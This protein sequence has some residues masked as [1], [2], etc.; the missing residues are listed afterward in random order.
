ML[1]RASSFRYNRQGAPSSGTVTGS[2]LIICRKKKWCETILIKSYHLPD[3]P[4]HTASDSS[5]LVHSSTLTI[6]RSGVSNS[7]PRDKSAWRL[8]LLSGVVPEFDLTS[9]QWSRNIPFCQIW[10][11][12]FLLLFHFF[13]SPRVSTDYQERWQTVCLPPL[14]QVYY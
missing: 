11:R 3:T 7:F 8:R 12:T 2:W 4:M 10:L 13:P 14:F 1:N 9:A 6:I 5:Y